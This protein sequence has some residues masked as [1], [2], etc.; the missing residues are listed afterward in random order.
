MVQLLDVALLQ[1]ARAYPSVSV[2]VPTSAPAHETDARLRG[3]AARAQ[4][5]LLSEFRNHEVRPL[6]DKLDALIGQVEAG[7]ERDGAL[8]FFVSRDVAVAVALPVAVRERVVIDET[9]ATRDLVHALHR[10]PHYWVL[11]L[12]ERVTRLFEGTGATLE[13]VTGGGFPAINAGADARGGPANRRLADHGFERSDHRE[14]RLRRYT[15][16][17]DAALAPHLR[18]DTAPVVLVG[19]GRRPLRFAETSKFRE[20]FAGTVAGAFE[21]RPAAELARLVRPTVAEV[22]A[23]QQGAALAEIDE[24]LGARRC[25]TGIDEVWRAANEGRGALLVVEENHDYPARVD[26]AT[27]A[28]APADDVEH[29]EVVDDV[30]DEAIEIVLAKRGR[31]VV[32]PDGALASHGRIAMKLRH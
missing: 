25:A 27:G 32:V 28:L 14:A 17:V 23:R 19:A 29:P 15:R 6:L 30:V 9:F 16:A 11:V 21:G 20:R 8:G 31:V 13:E 10:S 26:A 5:R 7:P 1:T 18:Q 24:A 2:L 22:I 4:A 3:L 12:D